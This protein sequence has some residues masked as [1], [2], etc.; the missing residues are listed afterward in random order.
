MVKTNTL[1]A[2]LNSNYKLNDDENSYVIF[3]YGLNLDIIDKNNQ[4]NNLYGCVIPLG[5]VKIDN[6]NEESLTKKIESYVSNMMKITNHKHFMI[7]KVGSVGFL[8]KIPDTKIVSK[9]LFDNDNRIIKIEDS[10]RKKEEE[11]EKIQEDI[12]NE[13]KNENDEGSLE[14]YKSDLLNCMYAYEQYE[15]LI[16]KTQNMYENF[17]DLRSL[18]TKNLEQNP[19]Y[20]EQFLPFLKEKLRKRGELDF[21]NY[22]EKSYNNLENKIF[23]T[24]LIK[25]N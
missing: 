10:E 15:N 11:Y 20:R 19:E 24:D 25:F 4:I 5:T 23:T 21:Y 9:F 3:A 17:T 14:K 22:V 12:K 16:K 6:K 18:V 2:I 13:R 8:E 7:I 1:Q